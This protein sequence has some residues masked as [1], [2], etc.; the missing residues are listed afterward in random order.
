MPSTEVVDQ[1]SRNAH[2]RLSPDDV[3]TWQALFPVKF[4]PQIFR[5]KSSAAAQLTQTKQST[6]TQNP[7][8]RMT[9]P[10]FSHTYCGSECKKQSYVLVMQRH[11]TEYLRRINLALNDVQDRYI[12]VVCLP[13]DR[14]RHHHILRLQQSTHHVQYR[15]L[16]NTCHLNI[17]SRR[18][19][20]QSTLDAPAASQRFAK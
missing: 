16:A 3:K 11:V 15:R 18:D 4:N 20:K 1:F 7:R 8:H 14:S 19:W 2:T 12:A 17:A 9:C 10:A 5:H 13:L 6:S